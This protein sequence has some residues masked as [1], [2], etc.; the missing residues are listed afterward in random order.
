MLSSEL[1]KIISKIE[2]LRRELESLNN[3]DLADPEVLAASRV[4]DA[5]L[6]EYYRLLKSKEEA[7]GSE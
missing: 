2:E 3:R 6:N 5:A 4:L 1:N 7:E